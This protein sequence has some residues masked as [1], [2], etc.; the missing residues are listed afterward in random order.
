MELKNFDKLSQNLY[1][2]WSN[3]AIN[4]S[5]IAHGRRV[6]VQWFF[7]KMAGHG[8]KQVALGVLKSI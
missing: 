8:L 2:T 7:D 1:Q 4:I 5:D 6:H 3:A